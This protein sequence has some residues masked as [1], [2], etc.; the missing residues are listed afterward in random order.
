MVNTANISLN[1]DVITEL[2][3]GKCVLIYV[4]AINEFRLLD[5]S[6]QPKQFRPKHKGEQD[7]QIW[8][9]T[10]DTFWVPNEMKS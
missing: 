3:E 10:C 8:M 4:P 2:T 6:Y 9:P 5:T 1:A 7:S